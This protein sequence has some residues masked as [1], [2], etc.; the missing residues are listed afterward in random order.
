M[1][2]QLDQPPTSKRVAASA[3]QLALTA[4][5]HR[6]IDVDVH[7][8]FDRLINAIAADVATADVARL[9]QITG[10]RAVY[11]DQP[12]RLTDS[13]SNDVINAP[14]VWTRT[15]PSGVPV[16]GRGTTVA[17]IDSGI[18]D[19]HPA[20][21]DKVVAGYDFVNDDDDPMD[22]NAH[23]THVAGIIA[24]VAPAAKLAAYKVTDDSGAAY[25]STV[26]AGIE[27]AADPANPHRADV[28]NISLGG[29]GDGT[30]PVGQA[31]TAAVRAGVVVAASAG[32]AGP[33]AQTVLTPAAADGVLAVGA[34]VS[35]LRTPTA[36]MVTPHTEKLQTYRVPFSANPPAQPVTAEV[37]DVGS[38]TPEEYEDIDVR[39]KIVLY[40][41]GVPTDPTHVIPSDIAQ[42]REAEHRGAVAAIGYY[43]SLGPVSTTFETRP[44]GLASGDD[45]RLDDLV[46]MGMDDLQYGVLARAMADGAV[47]VRIDGVDATDQLAS[48]SSRGPTSSYR[49]KPELVAPGVEIRSTVP[50]ALWEPGFYRMS[51]TS[52]ASPQV[53]GSAAL[54][55][56]LRPDDSAREIGSALIGSATPID[57]GPTD[58]GAG[59]LDVAAAADA[60]IT[61]TPAAASMGLADLAQPRIAATR[62]ITLHNRGDATTARITTRAATGN[63]DVSPKSVTIAARGTAKIT[64]T[65]SAATP[66]T[67]TDIAGW[68]V[69]R[70]ADAQVRVPYLLAARPLVIRTS[71]EPSDGATTAFIYSQTPLAAPPTLAVTAPDGTTRT[72]TVKLDHDTWYRAPVG[73]DS[74][75]T[76]RIQASA[77]T[78]RGPMLTGASAFEVVTDGGT[79]GARWQPVGPNAAAGQLATGPDGTGVTTTYG[80]VQP[81]LTGDYGRTWEQLGPLPVADGTG[82]VLV[83]PDNGQQLWYAV[84]SS[85]LGARLDPTYEGKILRSRDGGRSWTSLDVPDVRFETLVAGDGKLVAVTADAVL[86][87]TDDGD[88]WSAH[89]APLDSYVAGA[90][91][92]GTDLFVLTGNGVVRFPGVTGKPEH[93]E[94][95]VEGTL[96]DIAADGSRV[97]VTSWDGGVFAFDDD[98]WERLYT[99]PSGAAMTIRTAGGAI[100]VGSYTEEYVSRDGGATWSTMPEPVAGAIETDFDAWPDQ[101]GTLVASAEG[102]G[103]FATDN[104]GDSYRRTGVQGITIHDLTIAQTGN[105]PQLIAGTDQDV[106]DTPPPTGRV[107]PDT[108]EWGL[109]GYEAYIGASVQQ[110][111]AAPSDPRIVWKVRKS[112]LDDFY[113]YRSDD[114]GTTWQAKGNTTEVPLALVIDPAN[115]DRVIVSFWSLTGLGLY[116]TSDG[117]STWRKLYHDDLFTALAMDGRG[118]LWLGGDSG[119]YRSDDGGAT[120]TKVASG[121][122]TAIA[123]NDRRVVIGGATIRVSD[124]GGRTFATADTGGLPMQVSDIATSPRQT[125]YAGTTSYSANGL[126]QGG[127]GVLRSLDGGKTWSNISGGLQNTAVTSLQFA[128]DGTSLF[129]GTVN[130]GVHRLRLAP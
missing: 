93:I 48:F 65:A 88:T 4:A 87:S 32:N 121:A 95:P 96:W 101:P 84:S 3:Q 113:V 103:L 14:E 130:G 100:V 64:V 71:P 127:R 83:D 129:A 16:R 17:V 79:P 11:P 8:R 118:R 23:G 47:R 105:G 28:I 34:S 85:T 12:M 72:V 63:V 125:L 31:A 56:Q 80:S 36:T 66:T 45:L 112:A 7:R 54:L 119:L 123:L 5:E 26:I 75:G 116:T 10:V 86:V 109:S 106:Y 60:T 38:G 97:F 22:D 53:A 69:A 43:E 37:V 55:R 19:T 67:D 73:G 81:W 25:E 99:T 1:I 24:G 62:T 15:D 98:G 78:E 94:P 115:P 104:S 41:G 57:G 68:V 9:Q 122:V 40:S 91:M 46:V 13:A 74:P 51:G 107:T 90:A 18:D 20:L 108:A 61:A 44:H 49:Q 58:A 120:V 30:E 114:G 89:V 76:Y 128:P 27:A 39:G 6:G 117:G 124:D 70:T 52:M 82:T 111:Q 59:R 77:E 33:G 102:A 110:V 42:A 29:N 126:V 35:G 2:I 50:K 92:R 21:K